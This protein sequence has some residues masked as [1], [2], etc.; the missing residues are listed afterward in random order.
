MLHV[1]KK[2]IKDLSLMENSPEMFVG[3]QYAVIPNGPAGQNTFI[4]HISLRNINI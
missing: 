3:T 2:Y 4:F 1:S